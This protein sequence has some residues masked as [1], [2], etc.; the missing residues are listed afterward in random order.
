MGYT[1][2]FEG[3]FALDRPLS[4][5]Q[6]EYLHKFNATRRMK[7]RAHIAATM[8]DPVR[9]AVCLSLGGDDAP[10]FT[11]GLGFMGQ[12]RDASVV[13]GGNT[14]P[15]G[16]PGLWCQWVPTEDRCGI[17]WDGGEKF[18][19]YAEWLQY[20]MGHFLTLWG[21]TVSG[22]VSYQGENDD[23][24][25]VLRVVNGK[26]EKTEAPPE[27]EVSE[28]DA[29]KRL[30]IARAH[31]GRDTTIGDYAAKEAAR[32]ERDLRALGVDVDHEAAEFMREAVL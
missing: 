1:T 11:G 4:E 8:T 27:P 22:E 17:E 21:F 2:E 20:L 31:I 26:V 25:G 9:E 3:K 24:R 7:R 23:D 14:E 10:Y 12:D 13:D 29:W 6:A 19:R 28:V 15:D 32:A 16:Q 5:A 30:A 18:Y